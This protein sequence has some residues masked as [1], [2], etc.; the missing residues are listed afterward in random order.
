MDPI[1]TTAE[2]YGIAL[3]MELEAARRYVDL[4]LRM[5]TRRLVAWQDRI[6]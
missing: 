6:A 2:L 4:A 5:L 1:R 3:A